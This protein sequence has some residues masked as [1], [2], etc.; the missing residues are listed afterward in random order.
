MSYGVNETGDIQIFSS[1]STSSNA[2]FG[3][4]GR[5]EGIDEGALITALGLISYD[6][7]CV[8]DE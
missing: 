8:K 6:Y 7:Q 2:F 1:Y 3:F 5:R 4:V